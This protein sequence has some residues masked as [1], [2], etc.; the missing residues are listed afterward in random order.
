MSS[1][2]R[3]NLA[4]PGSSN[5]GGVEKEMKQFY[6][7]ILA[8]SR[9]G[10]LYVGVTS[11]LAARIWQHKDKVVGG[12][13][14]QYRVG[15]LVYYETFDDVEEAI[16]REKSVKRWKRNWKLSLIEKSNPG[17]RDLY[18]EIVGG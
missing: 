9:N 16:Q 2:P 14:K 12:F 13:T 6:V 11:D 3:G 4:K 15:Q 10:T 1:R 18:N 17:W 8:S 5:L 7:Y